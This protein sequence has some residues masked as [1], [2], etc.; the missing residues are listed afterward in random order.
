MTASER[1]GS[2]RYALVPL[3]SFVFCVIII[4]VSPALDRRWAIIGFG[5]ATISSSWRL[6]LHR[7]ASLITEN[8]AWSEVL[9]IAIPVLV[10][11][12]LRLGG[13]VLSSSAP[14]EIN[15]IYLALS[16]AIGFA[17]AHELYANT[18]IRSCLSA[19][20]SSLPL[21]LRPSPID[22]TEPLLDHSNT[23]Q[24]LID[25]TLDWELDE[26]L[27][28]RKRA[29][30]EQQ[31][32]VPFIDVPISLLCLQRV[33]VIAFQLGQSMIFARVIERDHPWP[34][35]AQTITLVLLFSCSLAVAIS[36][37]VMIRRWS[38]HVV[39][40]GTLLVALSIL[41]VSLGVWGVVV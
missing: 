33:D 13:L 11:E 20:R 37:G 40:Y 27:A 35:S 14:S 41:I 9:A 8:D 38:F 28:S 10:Q 12:L 21:A 17:S 22:D 5:A 32:G 4:V 26:L 7:L 36:W 15:S 30:V 25:E 24:G 16:Y 6:P 29:R 19:Y 34:V 3:V 1:A 18:E 39:A 23:E 2:A 31:M